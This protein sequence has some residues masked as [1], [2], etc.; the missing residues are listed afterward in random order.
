MC[1]LIDS[2]SCC[3][4]AQENPLLVEGGWSERDKA[5]ASAG[6]ARRLHRANHHYLGKAAS[7]PSRG[8]RHHSCGAERPQE[9]PLSAGKIRRG[10]AARHWQQAL[11]HQLVGNVLARLPPQE[12]KDMMTRV[13]TESAKSAVGALG[14]HFVM[15]MGIQMQT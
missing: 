9:G 1:R 14:A 8:L 5:A 12:A 7:H 3:S 2:E 13:R 11:L 6:E 10:P 15:S 4:N